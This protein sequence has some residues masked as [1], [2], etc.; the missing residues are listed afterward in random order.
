MWH[1]T[2]RSAFLALAF[3]VLVLSGCSDD[4]VIGLVFLEGP[5]LWH[6][7][8]I[9]GSTDAIPVVAHTNDPAEM[10]LGLI[11]GFPGGWSYGP[12][13]GLYE[14]QGSL[15]M[16][17]R[18]EGWETAV[19]A[20]PRDQIHRTVAQ[21]AQAAGTSRLYE[22]SFS[23][24]RLL[25]RDFVYWV[26]ANKAPRFA[27]LQLSLVD[28]PPGGR[29]SS[30]LVSLWSEL[31]LLLKGTD[32]LR[33]LLVFYLPEEPE[34]PGSGSAALLRITGN[35]RDI[36]PG[37]GLCVSSLDVAPTLGHLLKLHLLPDYPGQSLAVWAATQRRVR[38]LSLC[39]A[40][41]PMVLGTRWLVSSEAQEDPTLPERISFYD[42]FTGSS[43]TKPASLP[44]QS[45]LLGHLIHERP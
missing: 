15:I 5:Q 4:P 9:V 20:S 32:G 34:L 6:R 21:L 33:E 25:V 19:F 11:E 3:S 7:G 27:L 45:V 40:G 14:G 23:S 10:L 42:V 44:E 38:P 8:C 16:L 1:T 2:V 17:A 37:R 36:V 43:W 24:W 26:A 31:S 28:L 41:N 35:R 30:L 29:G 39:A 12:L 18:R 22:S 13:G